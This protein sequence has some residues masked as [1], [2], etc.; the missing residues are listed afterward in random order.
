MA[1][2]ILLSPLSLC[3]A[4]RSSASICGRILAAAKMM[5]AAIRRGYQMNFLRVLLLFAIS[6]SAIFAGTAQQLPAL[7]NGAVAQ[8]LETDSGGNIYVAGSLPPKNP[9]S[10]ADTSD[11]F[12]AKL[13]SDGSKV[14]YFSV[15]GGSGAD[16]AVALAVGSDDSAYVTGTTSSSDFPVTKGA[17][18]T[19]FGGE[20]DDAFAAKLNP[21]GAT[22]YATYI[23]EASYT[24][25]ENIAIDGAGDAFILGGGGIP[26]GVTPIAGVNTQ[27]LGGF[28][29][30]IDPTGSKML[31]GFAGLGG[32][33]IAVDGEGDV[34]LAGAVTPSAPPSPPPP[35]TAGAFQTSSPAGLCGGD[36][37]G[38]LCPYEYVA[39]VDPTGTQL[40][41]LT[42][43]NGTYGATPAGLAVDVNGSAI[44]A[45]ATPSPDFPVAPDALESLYPPIIPPPQPFVYPGPH[46]IPPPATGFVAKLNATGSALIWS[47]FFGGSR[48]DSI[49]SMSMDS[50]GDVYIAGQAGSSDLPGLS[51]APAGCRPSLIQQLSF[52]VRLTPDG[53][54]ASPAQ[55]FYGAPTYAYG[56]YPLTIT[57]PIAVAG[58]SSGAVV[59]LEKSGAITIANLFAPSRLACLTDPADNAQLLSVAPGQDLTLFGTVLAPASGFQAA[60]NGSAARI[61]YSSDA[62]VNVQVPAAIAGQSTVQMEVTNT[63]T[64][65]PLNETL[66]LAVVPQQPSVFLTDEALGGTLSPCYGTD[67]SAPAAVALNADGSLNSVSNPAAP[68]S[69]VTIFLNGIASGASVTG[70]AN[71][72]TVTFS[73]APGSN[74]GA[75][76]VSFQIPQSNAQA[77][78][79]GVTLTK[80]E[81]GGTLAR[82]NAVA[83]C[84][85]ATPE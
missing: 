60:F 41:Y 50:S 30:E 49:T 52:A 85:A 66:T 34:Y 55:L 77:P 47:T 29:I 51:D 15:L 80:L 74:E 75:L 61:L 83:V 5:L 53:A 40:I 58:S 57:G 12:V 3:G 8:A 84:V 14:L 6:A 71:D 26:P 4:F 9:K 67:G 68:G 82:E 21:N 37:V 11:A 62:Q 79:P 76:P 65:V 64:T 10:A 27:I 16:S 7:P 38:I 17:L 43:L 19:F 81:A 20:Q 32:E 73:A 48:S 2:P 42:G 70:L 13:S 45:G 72:S 54:S 56:Q 33:Y 28:V 63:T 69:R 44:L 18:Q 25:A 22:I 23:G 46:Y 59:G 39:K 1:S 35:F 36:F 31:M 78:T 24:F